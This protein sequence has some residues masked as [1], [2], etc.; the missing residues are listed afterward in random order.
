MDKKEEFKNQITEGYTFKGETE[1]DE[2][3]SERL[4]DL[5]YIE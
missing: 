4:R 2:I 3:V 1:S 5:G